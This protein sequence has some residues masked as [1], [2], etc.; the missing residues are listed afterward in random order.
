MHVMNKHVQSVCIAAYP[1]C[2]VKKGLTTRLACPGATAVRR[3]RTA[4][5]RTGATAATAGPRAR[6]RG[7]RE[8]VLSRPVE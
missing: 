2:L 1:Q 4:T 5:A 7:N 6:K 3:T 8:C